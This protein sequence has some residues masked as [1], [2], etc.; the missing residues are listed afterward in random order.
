M[1]KHLFLSVMIAAAA[2]L[3]VSGAG[4]S[5][6]EALARALAGGA[7]NAPALSGGMSLCH[8]ALMP[9]LTD[10]PAFYVFNRGV[11]S[12]FIIASADDN[13]VALLGYADSGSFDYAALPDNVRRW[14]AGYSRQIEWAATH[15]AAAQEAA[16]A[17]SRAVIA[18]ML[19]TKWDQESPY[20]LD[21]PNMRRG[22]AVTGCV[23]T[24]MAQVMNYHQWP[25]GNGKGSNSYSYGGSTMSYNFATHSFDWANMLDDYSG[26]STQAQ[27]NAVA[28]LMYACGV[29]VNMQYSPDESGALSY[30]IPFALVTY[31]GYDSEASYLERLF[32]TDRQWTDLVYSELAAGR[33]VIYGGNG[34]EGGHQ[35]VC[36][37]Y[38]GD[39]YFHFNWGWSGYCDGNYKLSALN[40]TDVG[41]GGGSGKF[42]YDQDIVAGVGRPGTVT[43]FTAP[44]TIN[45]S[46]SFMGKD[47]TLSG[48]TYTGTFYIANDGGIYNISGFTVSGTLGLCFVLPG[49]A[50][51]WLSVD[52]I[53]FGP[54]DPMDG[55]VYGFD[56]FPAK[57]PR[58][59]APGTYSIYPAFRP[60]GGSWCR[61]PVAADGAQCVVMTVDA[62]GK[63]TFSTG[64]PASDDDDDDNNG[65]GSKVLATSIT[66]D[67]SQIAANPGDVFTLSATILPANT[68][69]K[70][71]SWA[72]TNPDVASVDAAGRVTVLKDGRTDIVAF[73]RD[74][75]NLQ[76]RCTVIVGNSGIELLEADNLLWDVTTPAGVTIR[77]GADA[78]ALR[79]LPRGVYILRSGS[80]TLKLAR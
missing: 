61:I 3:T 57:F 21:C 28:N 34:D 29:S 13:A 44:I 79:S 48:D 18:P 35:F 75:S 9:A 51:E 15:G 63:T 53:E 80:R 7:D 77:R 69:D 39:D 12:G 54:A 73:T 31:F 42:N 71:V 30:M 32:Y 65:D 22:R 20:N 8:T 4:L 76:A 68:T 16:Q 24:A 52:D 41:V 70:S 43:G 40:P 55:S 6:E 36:D 1:R 26:S 56:S 78:A 17:P 33:P 37:G 49:G 10:R 46:D 62:A 38:S 47:F 25:Q 45:A 50:Q 66:L 74:G 67:R 14:L 60:D 59:T 11:D 5:P 72:S 27:K 23:A 2:G 58:Y 64:A 19:S